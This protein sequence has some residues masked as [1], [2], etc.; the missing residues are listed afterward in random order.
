[1]TAG[2]DAL[3]DLLG[4]IS[5]EPIHPDTLEAEAD[6]LEAVAQ[7]DGDSGYTPDTNPVLEADEAPPYSGPVNA[8]GQPNR[9][10]LKGDRRGPPNESRKAGGKRYYDPEV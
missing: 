2:D 10:P 8:G 9:Q 1:M 6:Y 3:A 5:D 4:D 7:A